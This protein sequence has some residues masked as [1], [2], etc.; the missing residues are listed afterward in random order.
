MSKNIQIST[1]KM[2]KISS[3]VAASEVHLT[4]QAAYEKVASQEIEGIVSKLV[5]AGVIAPS[6]KEP[7]IV[8][9][10]EDPVEVI[11]CLKTAS[12]YVELAQS[13]GQES[14]DKSASDTSKMSADDKFVNTLLG[15]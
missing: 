8:A 7:S 9:M 14:V 11:S 13:T 12:E 4:K 3:F 5:E 10:K 1:A 6:L 15:S 2:K